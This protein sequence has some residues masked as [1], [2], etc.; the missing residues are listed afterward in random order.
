MVKSY[1]A[2]RLDSALPL[3]RSERFTIRETS[4]LTQAFCRF[5]AHVFLEQ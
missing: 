2:E 4:R 1:S 5:Y 3:L